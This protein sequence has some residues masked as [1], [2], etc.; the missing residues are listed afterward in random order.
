MTTDKEYTSISL[1]EEEG[2]TVSSHH[3]ERMT[4]LSADYKCLK[5]Q[6]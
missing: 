5:D 3:M 6:C 4:D 2:I 1:G